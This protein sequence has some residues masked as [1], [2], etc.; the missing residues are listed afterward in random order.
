M[1]RGSRLVSYHIHSSPKKCPPVKI[2]CNIHQLINIFTYRI[3][4]IV[5]YPVYCIYSTCMYIVHIAKNTITN[6]KIRNEYVLLVCLFNQATWHR[7]DENPDFLLHVVDTIPFSA[8]SMLQNIDCSLQERI[9]LM[10][11]D[12][13]T[14][15]V[16]H[17]LD[18]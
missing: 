10:V 11:V 14:D 4:T 12:P 8:N 3:Y 6:I 13:S 18:R 17:V 2:K 15:D 1:A 5:N 9:L 7:I 16:P